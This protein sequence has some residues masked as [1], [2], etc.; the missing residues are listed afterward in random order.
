MNQSG[1]GRSQVLTKDVRDLPTMVLV[2][3]ESEDGG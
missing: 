3:D 1:I 2:E